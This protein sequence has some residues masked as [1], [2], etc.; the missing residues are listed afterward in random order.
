MSRGTVRSKDGTAIA[1]YRTGDGPPLVLVHGT[2]ADH[3]R[4][5]T[6]LGPLTE[7]FSVYTIDRRGRGGSGDTEPYAIER[8]F[9]DVAAVLDSIAEPVDL[10]GHS[11]GALC[12]LH[13]ARLTDNIAK[14]VLY[15]PPIPV[16]IEIV[17]LDVL[18][19]IEELLAAGDRDGAIVTF[20]TEIVRVPASDLERLRSLPAWQARVAAAHTVAREERVYLSFVF[21][22]KPFEALKV[23]TLLLQGGDSPPFLVEPI[24]MLSRLIPNARV[25]VMP[26][27]QHAAMDTGAEIWL[28]EVVGFLSE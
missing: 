15:E 1:W 4:W 24:N 11:H 28:K 19:R 8:E 9:E 23:P 25:A 18:Q 10:L 20:M 7:R 17:P 13:A 14:L 5:N 26:G 21:D 3:S 12:S 6:V 2:S 27:Q 16:G 22:P